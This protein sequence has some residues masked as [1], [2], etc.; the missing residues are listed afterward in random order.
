MSDRF[1]AVFDDFE[2]ATQA[3]ESEVV[4]KHR[5][6]FCPTG[7]GGGVDPSCSPGSSGGGASDGASGGGISG[8]PLT[9]GVET[10][11]WNQ[12]NSAAKAATKKIAAMEKLAQEGKWA[13]LAALKPEYGEGMNSYQKSTIKAYDNLMAASK[14]EAMTNLP[15]ASAKEDAKGVVDASG[16]K[17]V[18]GQL[19]SN[20]GGTYL[21]P[22]GTK[23][24]VK[25]PADEKIARNEV[26]AAKL[27]ELSQSSV[28][29]V[30]LVEIDGKLGVA[31]KWIDDSK[32][33][34]W[35]SA[36]QREAASVDFA[37][38]AWLANWDAVGDVSQPDNIRMV[39]GHPV[40]VDVG[41]SLEYRAQGGTKEFGGEAKEWDTLRDP[42]IN[43]TAAKAFGGM[44][45]TQLMASSL[46][47][48]QVSDE[49][50]RALV[51]KYHGGSEME[52]EKLA[53]I[54]ISRRDDIRER[55]DAIEQA[56]EQ[57]AGGGKSGTPP[58]VPPPPVFGVAK[59]TGVYQDKVNKIHELA[60]K[61]DIE[62]IKALKTTP[63][64]VQNY[65]KTIHSYK[66]NV[67]AAL[68][69][70]AVVSASADAVASKATVTKV[71]ISKADL[72]DPPEFLG[73]YKAVNE[74]IAS[75]MIG[76]A[77][78]GDVEG[79]KSVEVVAGTK[80]AAYK[81]E[82][83]AATSAA[84]VKPSKAP[85]SLKGK[86]AEINSK[87]S[88][89]KG[90]GKEK[91]GKY[92]V[93]AKEGVVPSELVHS[94]KD[95][96]YKKWSENDPRWAKGKASWSKLPQDERD[97]VK[98]YT[99]SGYGVMNES[100]RSHNPSGSALAAAIGVT[101][102]SID[103]APGTVLSRQHD[104]NK[105]SIEDLIKSG[106]GTIV[107]DPG[108][109]STSTDKNVWSGNVQWKLTAGPGVR[110]LPARSFTSASA[111]ESEVLLPPNTRYFVTHV[112]EDTHGRAIV[113]AIILPFENNQCCPP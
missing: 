53:N 110:G 90:P 56:D 14:G 29:K 26:L 63:D 49:D 101:K 94:A 44:T 50:V 70:G 80:V 27:Y 106:P 32:L 92:L 95:S 79:L 96:Y 88:V 64:A 74:T 11:H 24:Y 9:S 81:A 4:P 85:Q 42:S 31:S 107:Q 48:T 58:A 36:A 52:K 17:Q 89:I 37:T 12:T 45:A 91:I 54:L 16:W 84:L 87:A 62:G 112:T 77:T 65:A 2:F 111:T 8:Q 35:D 100:L 109:I 57:P 1:A 43:P 28:P 66:Q 41:G 82:L 71:S 30:G 6:A 10:S 72:P 68:G 3:A 78:A 46:T 20:K 113:Q 99:G 93:V 38:H 108:I 83:I 60:K 69:A 34:D 86:L 59:T 103:I 15:Q 73:S 75:T 25:V 39:G 13:E 51:H 67:L 33:V 98:F 18:G 23:Y 7:P 105:S 76:Y 104:M 97:A 102:A 19:G 40:T 61:G 5:K 22:D 55:V 21:A 47:V